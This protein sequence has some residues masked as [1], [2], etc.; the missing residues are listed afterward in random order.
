MT[1]DV[2]LP[3]G[4]Y[5]MSITAVSGTVRAT[6]IA[7]RSDNNSYIATTTN[8]T[9]SEETTLYVGANVA[10]GTDYNEV[11]HIQIESGSTATAWS[12]YENLCPIS[13]RDSVEV[14]AAGKNLFDPSGLS[15]IT[16]FDYSGNEQTR[17]G[18]RLDFPAG[19]FTFSAKSISGNQAFIYINIC[20]SDGTLA[21]FEYAIGGQT[22]PSDKHYTL[23]DGQY[24]LIFDAQARTEA[25]VNKFEYYNIQ[26][27][28]GSTATEYEPYQGTTHTIPLPETVYGAKLDAVNGTLTVDR[29]F[30]RV[31]DSSIVAGSDSVAGTHRYNISVAG[32]KR[33]ADATV[34]GNLICS[35]YP[36]VT[37]LATYRVTLGASVSHNS[38][39]IYIYDPEFATATVEEFKTAKGDVQL[40]YE[41]A[42]PI[43][44]DLDP[45]Q[46]AT[47]ANQT[48]NVWTDA[49]DVTVEYAADLKTYID[50]K[51]AAAVA[52]M[53]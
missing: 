4:T 27:E 29:A 7:N 21:L 24:I 5:T 1:K 32:I 48:N 38:D 3:A 28:L 10:K 26:I 37:A 30:V 53:S 14:E 18:K 46:I 31:A 8:I 34:L 17:R 51:I 23:T 50:Q 9:L 11:V 40:V 43:V 39:S 42:T 41:L 6:Y 15:F 47:I 36:N 2:T 52:A 20:N 22:E 45:V 33:V 12:P 25:D 16:C 49:G 35:S 19:V 13:G 44:I